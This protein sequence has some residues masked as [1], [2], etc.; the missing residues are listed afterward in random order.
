ME[1]LL[2]RLAAAEQKEIGGRNFWIYSEDYFILEKPKQVP[3]TIWRYYY[4]DGEL[5]YGISF[6]QNQ[7]NI[8]ITLEEFEEV[9]ATMEIEKS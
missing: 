2:D 5:Y 3:Y 1:N 4:F 9:L 8:V 6:F 7:E